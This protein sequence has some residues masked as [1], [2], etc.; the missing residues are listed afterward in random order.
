MLIIVATCMLF[1]RLSS[2]EAKQGLPRKA[3][4]KRGRARGK[5]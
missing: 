2:E 5:K 3:R 4:E 1:L